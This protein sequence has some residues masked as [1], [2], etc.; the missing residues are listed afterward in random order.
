MGTDGQKTEYVI[1][2]GFDLTGLTNYAP[3]NQNP[4]GYAI[5]V[6]NSDHNTFENLAI[7]TNEGTGIYF[8]Q[9]YPNSY[10]LVK[11]VDAFN[12]GTLRSAFANI[13]GN[14]DGFGFH[15]Y[16]GS[17]GNVFYGCRA[18]ANCDD[19]FDCIAAAEQ[20]VWDHC[21]S[22]FN[23]RIYAAG[24]NYTHWTTSLSNF[25]MSGD[26][27][28]FKTGGW[29]MSAPP[30][31][32]WVANF[33]NAEV[34]AGP[35]QVLRY[36]LAVGH[37]N[38]NITSNYQLGGGYFHYNTAS[39]AGAYA[40]R[41]F[42]MMER[43]NA[44]QTIGQYGQWNTRNSSIIGN[45]SIPRSPVGTPVRYLDFSSGII[46]KN[47]FAVV[48]NG[49]SA[50]R[51]LSWRTTPPANL[52][53]PPTDAAGSTRDIIQN[54]IGLTTSHFESLDYNLMLTPRNADGSLPDIA[55]LRPVPGSPADGIGYTSVDNNEDGFADAWK[56]AGAAPVL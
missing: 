34:G 25:A 45:V 11:N 48:D 18:W 1:L 27:N 9:D 26:A 32:H 13:N 24:T 21:W 47:S 37:S 8:R 54:A 52:N 56:K 31:A 20:I 5:M 15:G 7:Y 33:G 22:A 30:I 49:S 4:N 14:C 36:G 38:N 6:Y 44:T 2:Y 39:Q 43:M 35:M 29:A 19:G 42:E 3:N 16:A 51:G 41:D 40:G 17:V 10:N 55:Y 50:L 46:D 53:P 28:G 12:N 23:G